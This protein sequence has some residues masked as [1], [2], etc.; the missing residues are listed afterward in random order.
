MK[1]LIYEPT[2]DDKTKGIQTLT[3][4]R[5][6]ERRCKCLKRN[7]TAPVSRAEGG[8]KEEYHAEPRFFTQSGRKM[9]K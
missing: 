4:D 3:Q 6:K 7:I 2:E 8:I 9:L 5:K 1:V